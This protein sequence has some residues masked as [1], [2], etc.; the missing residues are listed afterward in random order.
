MEFVFELVVNV[1][2]WCFMRDDDEWS[3]GRIVVTLVTL[4]ALMLL[5]YWLCR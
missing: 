2:A 1:L 4:I 3:V 5:G